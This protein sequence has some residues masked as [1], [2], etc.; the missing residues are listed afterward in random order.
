MVLVVEGS[1]H[2]GNRF[3][4]FVERMDIDFFH[5]LH[6]FLVFD[7]IE[8]VTHFFH[9]HFYLF[10]SSVFREPLAL[11]EWNFIVRLRYWVGL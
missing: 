7:V 2:F 1:D 11:C 9:L 3:E 4:F 6:T 10:D 8:E 5:Y